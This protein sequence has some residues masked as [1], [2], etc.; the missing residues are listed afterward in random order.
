MEALEALKVDYKRPNVWPLPQW[1]VGDNTR[2]RQQAKE[3][4]KQEM[5]EKVDIGTV[6]DLAQV[7]VRGRVCV[8]MAGEKEVGFFF[9]FSFLFFFFFFSSVVLL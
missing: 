7:M 9:L 4:V 1:K 5:K 8:V 2:L 3:K 6:G